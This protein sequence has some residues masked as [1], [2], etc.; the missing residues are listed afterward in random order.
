MRKKYISKMTRKE[1]LVLAK[2][3]DK[4]LKALEDRVALVDQR[5]HIDQLVIKKLWNDVEKLER[6]VG[7]L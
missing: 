5:T 4:E 6:K 2:T 7:L 3:L 1:L